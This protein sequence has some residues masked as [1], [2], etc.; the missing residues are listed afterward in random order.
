[1]KVFVATSNMSQSYK[2]W[3][4]TPEV[5]SREKARHGVDLLILTGGQDINPALYGQPANGAVWFD[6]TRDQAEFDALAYVMDYCPDV[7]ILG[8]CRGMQ[9][10]HVYNRG[11]LIQD[12]H[13]LG[14]SH[15]GAHKITHQVKHPL[16]YLEVVNSL[17]HQALSFPSRLGRVLAVE[18]ATSIPEIV[19]WRDNMLGV[20]FHPEMFEHSA[21]EKFFNI[22]KS[23]VK[24]DVSFKVPDEPSL[25]KHS[26][27]YR[28]DLEPLRIRLRDDRTLRQSIG[29]E[30]GDENNG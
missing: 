7:K 5:F 27:E 29:I 28:L 10:L 24:G 26:G 18:P 8:V 9:M 13:R 22:I 4:P 16:D 3:L 30:T 15:P 12:L 1:M 17:H 20:Q 6:D 11:I 14:Q 25:E 23:W 19:S 2:N 21:G